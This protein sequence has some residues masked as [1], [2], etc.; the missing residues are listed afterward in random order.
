MGTDLTKMFKSEHKFKKITR[1]KTSTGI[2]NL[3]NW[4]M[5]LCTLFLIYEYSQK[6]MYLQQL[7][8]ILMLSILVLWQ[9]SHISAAVYS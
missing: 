7:F 3:F 2:H 9:L 8:G 4:S 6:Q 5:Y 1:K